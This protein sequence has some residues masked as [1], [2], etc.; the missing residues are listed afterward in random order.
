MRILDES[1]LAEHAIFLC[2]YVECYLEDNGI[3][4]KGC[5]FISKV[6]W[7]NLQ[8]LSLRKLSMI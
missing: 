8:T 2:W 5:E 7:S 1:K 3:G 6:K 4:D